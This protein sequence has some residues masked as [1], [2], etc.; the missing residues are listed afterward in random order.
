MQAIIGMNDVSSED[1]LALNKSV[2]SMINSITRLEMMLQA[3][4]ELFSN[5]LTA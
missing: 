4:L 5:D 1:L 3:K 2:D